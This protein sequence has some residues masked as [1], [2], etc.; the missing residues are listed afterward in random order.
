MAQTRA[1]AIIGPALRNQLPP[2]TRS[3][4]LT[5]EP[6]ASLSLKTLLSGSHALEALLIG[7]H[8]KKLYIQYNSSVFHYTMPRSTVQQAKLS[9]N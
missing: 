5:G 4:L 8:C 9:M 2:L 7:V 1:F 3:N 6:R